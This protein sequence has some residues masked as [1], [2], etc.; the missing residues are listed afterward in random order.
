MASTKM[1]VLQACRTIRSQFPMNHGWDRL[2]FGIVERHVWD[3]AYLPKVRWS[4]ARQK[5]NRLQGVE[6]TR[7]QR[8]YLAW[9]FFTEEECWPAKQQGV[10]LD[11]IVMV[12]KQNDIWPHRFDE[13]DW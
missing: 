10:D 8:A 13:G 2:F 11:W 9:K 7:Q 1:K 12:C 3:L 5:G 6:N 4:I